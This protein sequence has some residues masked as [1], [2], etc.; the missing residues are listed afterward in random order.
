ME[1]LLLEF[2]STLDAFL[3]HLQARAGA[4]L[5]MSRLTI[6]QFQYIDAIYELGEPTITE[7]AERLKITKASVTAGIGK[8]EQMGYV[9]KTQSQS[10]KRVFHVS[11]TEK[12]KPLIQAKYQAL[13]EYG[14]FI[15]SS[16]SSEEI[17][18]F[19]MI[20]TKLV[21]SFRQISWHNS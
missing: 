1:A 19:E 12:G 17:R 9:Q 15:Q 7:I 13:E 20:L 3:K 5:G 2:V 11:L 8:L 6:N 21:R 4:D 16:L 10:D 18:Q 14:K